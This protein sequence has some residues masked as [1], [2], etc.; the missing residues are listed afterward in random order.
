MSGVLLHRGRNQTDEGKMTTKARYEGQKKRVLLILQD[1][2]E[3]LASLRREVASDG[4]TV[5]GE[6]QNAHKFFKE[7]GSLDTLHEQML[8]ELDR[9]NRNNREGDTE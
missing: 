9:E 1:L 8:G 5:G 4:W 7:L 2:K 6:L 3:S